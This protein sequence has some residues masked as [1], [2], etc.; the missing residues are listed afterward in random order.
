[1]VQQGLKLL[2]AAAGVTSL[3]ICQNK[4]GYGQ[5]VATSETS[6][7]GTC[8]K[9]VVIGGG[10]AGVSSAYQLARRGYQVTVLDKAS[11]PGSECSAVSAGGMQRSNP[12]LNRE[13]WL[14]VIK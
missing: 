7:E 14:A 3:L 8:K 6:G 5:V 11:S 12:V 10:V 1:M 4:K 9:A 13:S 2:G